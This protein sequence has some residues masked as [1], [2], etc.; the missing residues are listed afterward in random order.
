MSNFM[1]VPEEQPD[2][3]YLFRLRDDVIISIKPHSDT[4]QEAQMW[5][6]H[7]LLAPDIGSMSTQSFRDKLVSAA[8]SGFNESEERDD[9]GKVTKPEKINVPNIAEDINLVATVMGIPG[10]DGKSI[11]EKLQHDEGTTLL[12]RLIGFAEE[13][14]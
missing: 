5:R 12:E 3:S 10:A 4:K 2:G 6:K 13:H 7:V 8:K 1:P 9:K 11:R 14:A